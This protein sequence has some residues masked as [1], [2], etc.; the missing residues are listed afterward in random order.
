MRENTSGLL[1]SFEA[2]VIVPE[3][4]QAPLKVEL[5]RLRHAAPDGN[6]PNENPLVHDGE[7]LVPNV[8]HVVGRDQKMFFFY[9]VY[10]PVSAASATPDVRTSLAFYK[11]KIKVYETP[12]VERERIDDS[13]RHA[14]VFHSRYRP[15][16]L[17]RRRLYLPGE[18]HRRGRV[19]VCVSPPH[20][21]RQVKAPARHALVYSLRGRRVIVIL[22]SS[23]KG[24]VSKDET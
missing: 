17:R 8:T 3:L 18:H 20:A 4:K 5:D 22:L 21:A 2:A 11:G 15:R 24:T 23:A 1:G 12:M 16:R 13:S 7:Q 14:A 19:E 10:D 9:E 6:V